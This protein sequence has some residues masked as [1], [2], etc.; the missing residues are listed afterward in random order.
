MTS[1]EALRRTELP[2]RLLVLG[3]GYIAVELGGA[4]AGAGAEVEF[5]VRSRFLRQEDREISD[6][7]ARVFG[8][9]HQVHAG[10]SPTRVAYTSPNFT[11]E[12]A[13]DSP[14]SG[15]SNVSSPVKRGEV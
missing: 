1:K 5:I 2:Q 14:D 7:F 11:R 10:F 9:Q 4:Y 8:A 13:F 12:D 15:F 6:E 3:A